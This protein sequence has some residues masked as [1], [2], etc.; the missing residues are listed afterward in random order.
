[1][2]NFSPGKPTAS[3]FNTESYGFTHQTWPRFDFGDDLA[4]SS[5]IP[6][7]Q[8]HDGRQAFN[9]VGGGMD[10]AP[11]SSDMQ[12]DYHH[13]HQRHNNQ[14][15]TD[16]ELEALDT[17]Q[18]GAGGRVVGRL[19]AHFENK[20]FNPFE[21]KPLAPPVPPRPINTDIS[22]MNS[23]NGQ[24]HHQHTLQSP[25][26][27]MNSFQTNLGFDPL[28]YCGSGA[29]G[30]GGNMGFNPNRNAS[31]VVMAGESW[32]SFDS[33]PRVTSPISM[34][35]PSLSY[36]SYQ[37]NRM[38]SPIATPSSAQFGSL[39]DFMSNNRMRS[40][41]AH[42]PMLNT[43]MASSPLMVSPVITSSAN[44]I[45]QA[46]GGTPGFEIWRP[47]GT[48]STG[49]DQSPPKSFNNVNKNNHTNSA[50]AMSDFHNSGNRSINR[51]IDIHTT[52]FN[53][54]NSNHN[55][56][57]VGAGFFK[58]PVPKTPK[59]NMSA[60]S[61]FI[62]ELNPSARAKGKAPTKPP[63]PKSSAISVTTPPVSAVKHEPG[64][65]KPLDVPLASS[66]PDCALSLPVSR[67]QF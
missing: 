12:T 18:Q 54:T 7:E 58:P 65:A 36:G 23:G 61:Q 67:A 59:P 47:P 57:T 46:V 41:A 44:Q 10:W 26:V 8:N 48:T 13:G 66:T 9:H 19:V 38:A 15:G 63:R 51:N 55:S 14:G 52:P 40:P 34:S 60:G 24:H 28:S 33:M 6:P 5:E 25:S 30:G 45:A 29:G 16:M 4:S 2:F 50:S 17:S 43:H 37:E 32:G 27:G 39:D 1:M 31:P 62:L 21:Q 20:G 11:T 35:P 49:M 53:I 42:S 22:N 3:A 56:S 64:T